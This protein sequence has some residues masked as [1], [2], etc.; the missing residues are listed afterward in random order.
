MEGEPVAK[1]NIGIRGYKN[2]V[3]QM[4]KM[5]KDAEKTINRT[6]G[7]IRRRAPA[8]VAKSA[9]AVYGVQSSEVSKSGKA[10]NVTAIKTDGKLI[11]G[12]SITYKGRPLTPTHFKMKPKT[13][14]KA[15]KDENGK[16]VRKAKKYTVTAEIFKGQRVGLGPNVFLGTNHHGSDIPYQRKGDARLPLTAIKTVSV[17][18]MVMNETVNKDLS[19]RIGNILVERL[20]HN[21]DRLGK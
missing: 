12:V 20:N 19:E 4:E 7:D 10:T 15:I 3:K 18:Q 2:L 1:A 9:T 21:I 8:Q 11:D 6:M 13:R 16:T 14:P 5:E 17:P